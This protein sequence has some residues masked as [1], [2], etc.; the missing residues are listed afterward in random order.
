MGVK[1]LN[2]KFGDGVVFQDIFEYK[3]EL[4]ILGEIWGMKPE[5]IEVMLEDLRENEDY[6]ILE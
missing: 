1:N 3:N 6:I 5:E 2:E 4:K